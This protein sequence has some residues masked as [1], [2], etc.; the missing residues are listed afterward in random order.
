MGP[1]EFVALKFEGSRFTGEIIP[2]LS[3]LSSKGVVRLIDLIIMYKTDSGELDLI[4]LTRE[5]LD[6]LGLF[7]EAF[8]WF[9]IDDI[10]RVGE[11][12]PVGATAA[13]ILFEHAWA[14]HLRELIIK[15]GGEWIADARISPDLVEEVANY[16]KAS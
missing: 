13:M 12:L 11:S 6:S 1:L 4:E 7:G 14:G 5:E 2:E 8:R 15:A 10:E 16:I 9:A 3:A